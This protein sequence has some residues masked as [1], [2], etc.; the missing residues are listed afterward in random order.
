[1]IVCALWDGHTVNRGKFA[2]A[3]PGAVLRYCIGQ[4]FLA[5]FRSGLDLLRVYNKWNTDQI[6]PVARI[7]LKRG[8]MDISRGVWG[9]APPGNFPKLDALRWLLRPFGTEAE[10]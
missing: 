9:H 4:T 5:T 3:N 7:F 2:F 6:R 1:M 10:P 8:Y